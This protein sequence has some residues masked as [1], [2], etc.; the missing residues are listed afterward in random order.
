MDVMPSGFERSHAPHP[1]C[2]L[3]RHGSAGTVGWNGDRELAAL[4]DGEQLGPVADDL[5]CGR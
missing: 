2:G 4:K 3:A 1:P 5:V